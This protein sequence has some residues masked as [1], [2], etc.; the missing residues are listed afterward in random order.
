M[1]ADKRIVLDTSVLISSVLLTN[2]VPAKAVRLALR[3]GTV[4]VSQDTL[5]ELSAVL[6]RPS[7]L[8]TMTAKQGDDYLSAYAAAAELTEVTTIVTACRDPDDDK[9]LALAVSGQADI[10]ITGDTDLLVLDPF[11]GVR[12]LAPRAYLESHESKP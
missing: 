8:A 11:Q 2:S 10:I 4:L 12:I 1:S 3:S 6:K 9:I 7:I 5:T